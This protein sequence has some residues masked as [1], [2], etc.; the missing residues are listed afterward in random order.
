MN[1]VAILILTLSYRGDLSF[2]EA[3]N[4][5]SRTLVCGADTPNFEP[6]GATPSAHLH[7]RGEQQ[8]AAPAGEVV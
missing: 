6:T 3:H 8:V 4:V 2:T 1:Q 5:S 7:R